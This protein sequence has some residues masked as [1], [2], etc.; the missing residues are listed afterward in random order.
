[1][2]LS[3]IVSKEHDLRI[4]AW[5]SDNGIAAGAYTKKDSTAYWLLYL[6]QKPGE[7]HLTIQLNSDRLKEQNVNVE[8]TDRDGEKVVG[9]KI[10]VLVGYRD[11][12]NGG[13]TD[14]PELSKTQSEAVEAMADS[15][16]DF[17]CNHVEVEDDTVSLDDFEDVGIFDSS[18][19]DDEFK[20]KIEDDK[21]A[22]DD[23]RS[24]IIRVFDV[25][26]YVA[27][28]SSDRE[29]IDLRIYEK[30]F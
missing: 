6:T 11:D 30:T 17:I 1:M 27:T 24:Y 23:I 8:F 9:Q 22:I 4:R 13:D 5:Y 14:D 16:I 3:K 21:V 7:D 10:Y 25:C 18:N 19:F 29:F 15:A 26:A 28:S 12:D 2:N 20:S